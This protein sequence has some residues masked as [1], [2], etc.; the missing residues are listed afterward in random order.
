MSMQHGLQGTG[1]GA[2]MYSEETLMQCHFSPTLNPHTDWPEVEW[3]L[4]SAK[5][6][7]NC[8]TMSQPF[9]TNAEFVLLE[10]K[11]VEPVEEDLG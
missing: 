10:W 5:P 9:N 11:F 1:R 2:P 6:E 4:S 8:C 7:T 3:D